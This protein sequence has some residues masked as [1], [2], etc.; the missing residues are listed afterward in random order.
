MTQSGA[1]DTGGADTGDA[2][3]EIGKSPEKE[4]ENSTE[5]EVGDGGKQE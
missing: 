3:G 2:Q 1:D 5:R 4:T